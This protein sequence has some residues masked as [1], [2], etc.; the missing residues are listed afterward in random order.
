MQNGPKINAKS[1]PKM[2]CRF[3]SQNCMLAGH[4]PGPKIDQKSIENSF[5]N[6]DLRHCDFIDPSGAKL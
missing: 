4:D 2:G 1:D 3:A 6:G 5:G